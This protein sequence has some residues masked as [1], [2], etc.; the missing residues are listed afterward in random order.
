MIWNNRRPCIGQA[1]PDLVLTTA[2]D[3][4][5]MRPRIDERANLATTGA[6]IQTAAPPITYF[7][8]TLPVYRRW[9]PLGNVAMRLLRTGLDGDELRGLRKPIAHTGENHAIV[10]PKTF[11]AAHR[12]QQQQRQNEA[13]HQRTAAGSKALRA[14]AITATVRRNQSLGGGIVCH[15]A[16][17]NTDVEGAEGPIRLILLLRR[18]QSKA[19]KSATTNFSTG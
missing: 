12:L 16:P 7:L 10:A 14:A 6:K 9:P 15:T 19:R 18:G 13:F 11:S 3:C 4:L 17:R 2:E 1:S 5:L 8:P